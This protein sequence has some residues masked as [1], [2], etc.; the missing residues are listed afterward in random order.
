MESEAFPL[1][2]LPEDLQR[3]VMR[4]VPLRGLAQLACMRKS[5]RTAYS[6][7]VMQRDEIVAARVSSDF[8]SE[9]RE[10]LSYAK[11]SLPR[12]LIVEPPV[13]APCCAPSAEYPRV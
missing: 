13:G 10:R 2:D 3:Q 8:T 12:D 4:F 7:R 6:E 5:L 1:F 9:Y 11:T